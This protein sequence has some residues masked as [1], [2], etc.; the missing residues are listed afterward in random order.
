MRE[1]RKR[2]LKSEEKQKFNLP[3]NSKAFEFCLDKVIEE[4]CDE[5]DYYLEDNGYEIANREMIPI[6]TSIFNYKVI[7]YR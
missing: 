4:R 2:A 5:F 3:S 7:A 1:A 6:A